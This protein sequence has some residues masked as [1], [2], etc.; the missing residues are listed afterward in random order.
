MQVAKNYG[1]FCEE[2]PEVEEEH[3]GLLVDSMVQVMI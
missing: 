2:L 1:L 3:G